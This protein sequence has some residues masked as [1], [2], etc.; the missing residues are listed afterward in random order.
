MTTFVWT[1]IFTSSRVRPGGIPVS[2]KREIGDPAVAELSARTALV[3]TVLPARWTLRVSCAR[4]EYIGRVTVY[5]HVRMRT[6]SMLLT[7]AP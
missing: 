1:P 3:T 7:C 2:G 4:C 5:K 6:V